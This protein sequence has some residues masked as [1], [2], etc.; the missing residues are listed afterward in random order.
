MNRRETLLSGELAILRAIPGA[1]AI[2][3]EQGNILE[4]NDAWKN[5]L[6]CTNWLGLKPESDNYIEHCRKATELGNDYA[7][8]LLLG[9]RDVL[10]NPG[11][12]I[13]LT[14]SAVNSDEK[15]WCKVSISQLD[16]DKNCVLVVFDDVTSNM[17]TIQAL[18]ESEERYSQHFKHSVSGIIIGTPEGN[19]LDANRA[20]CQILGYTKDELKKGGRPLIVD[21]NDP[22]HLEMMKIREDT[23]IFE[24]EKEYIRKD[25]QKISVEITSVLH[26]NQ[27][28]DTQIINTFRDNST[29]KKAQFSLDEERRFT[30]TA[31]DS[32]P[33]IFFVVNASN[34]CIRWNNTIET[35]LGYS[36]EEL[37]SMNILNLFHPEEKSKALENFDRIF[38]EGNGSF[39]A[40]ISA[41]D[42]TSRTFQLHFNR[43]DNE[44]EPFLTCTGVDITLLLEV[45]KEKTE[46]YALM[47]QLFKN[48]PL[49]TVMIDLNGR[50]KKVNNGFLSLFDY[51]EHEVLGK[52]V[53]SLITNKKL[54][55]EADSISQKALRGV[56]TQLE[57]VRFDKNKNKIPVLI[58]TVPIRNNGSILAAYGIYV[59]LTNQKELEK[60]LQQ[61]LNEKD[62]LL[63]E[64][65]HRVKNNLAII[66]GL[67]ELQIMHIENEDN[68]EQLKEALSRVFSIAN[69]HETLYQHEDVVRIRFDKY[70]DRIIDSLPS[71]MNKHVAEIKKNPDSEHL[72]LNL[73][74][75]VPL[76]LIINELI[77]LGI[78]NE[79]IGEK[80][81]IT[82]SSDNHM[83]KLEI[84]GINPKINELKTGL[85]PDTFHKLLIK[86]F[87]DQIDARIKLEES[88]SNKIVIHFKKSDSMKGANSSI[89]DQYNLVKK[90]IIIEN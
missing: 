54:S 89:S 19:I 3:D 34:E 56:A 23:T 61:S 33:G 11:K 38:E 70:L 37:N 28:G 76:G 2:I 52:N 15:K 5:G 27:H 31:L 59:D 6:K 7:L 80:I 22:A 21:E 4:M 87:L 17:N 60:E 75:A 40:R 18:K 50:V 29:E 24:G 78:A 69:I 47:N 45:E 48:S 64:V 77:N 63:Q 74:Q 16:N 39:V 65:H 36:V 12:V 9:I 62:V 20:A 14:I 25:G 32:I 30:R 1:A 79:N 51:P 49:A 10:E 86:T 57:T 68:T 82:L 8:K 13:Q 67:L 84:D 35:E 85:K 73:N 42:G 41:K 26:R 90:Q 83:V 71:R 81:A 44:D 88:T 72:M 55:E 66:A 46:N 53:N 58:N 43:F